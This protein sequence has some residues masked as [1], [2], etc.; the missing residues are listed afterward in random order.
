MICGTSPNDPNW[1]LFYDMK[2]WDTRPLEPAR[3]ILERAVIA[4]FLVFLSPARRI[5]VKQQYLNHIPAADCIVYGL[6]PTVPFCVEGTRIG[7]RMGI[8]NRPGRHIWPQDP[9]L[10]AGQDVR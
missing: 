6:A 4:P 2:G 7:R 5:G 9:P 1:P 8:R 3:R 10:C